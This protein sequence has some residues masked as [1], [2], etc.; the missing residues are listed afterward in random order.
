V[1]YVSCPGEVT[2][3]MARDTAGTGETRWQAWQDIKS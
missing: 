3:R 2:R 1:E